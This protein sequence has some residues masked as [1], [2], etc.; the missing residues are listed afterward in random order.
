MD[1][2]KGS[3]RDTKLCLMKPVIK[4]MMFV[5]KLYQNGLPNY[6]VPVLNATWLQKKK[7]K[8][9]LVP[10]NFFFFFFYFYKKKK[11]KKN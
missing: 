11:K 9:K 7:K 3:K 2:K 10:L 4:L 8:K 5:K 1:D 6:W